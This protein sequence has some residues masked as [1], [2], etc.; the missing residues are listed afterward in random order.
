MLP[1]NVGDCSLEAMSRKEAVAD[2]ETWRAAALRSQTAE[3][4]ANSDALTDEDVV[5]MV[6]ELR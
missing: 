3:Q 2:L 6:H 4:A 5:R 1:E